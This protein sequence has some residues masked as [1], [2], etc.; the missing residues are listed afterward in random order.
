MTTGWATN[1]LPSIPNLPTTYYHPKYLDTKMEAKHS[2]DYLDNYRSHLFPNVITT[3][4]WL[5]VVRNQ[6]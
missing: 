4:Q 1:H 6:I 3:P 2:S 5:S